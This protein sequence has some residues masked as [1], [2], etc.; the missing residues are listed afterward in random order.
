MLSSFYGSAQV[1]AVV[2]LTIGGRH[3]QIPVQSMPLDPDQADVSPGG[4]FV[5]PSGDYGIVVGECA[6]DDEF[7]EKIAAACEDAVRVI[8]REWLN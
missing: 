3:V 6:T 4:F 7:N 8:G 2:D 5:G 1:V